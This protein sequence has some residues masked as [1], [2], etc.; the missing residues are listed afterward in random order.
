MYTWPKT[1]VGWKAELPCEGN[2]LS[3]LMHM[4][5][6]ASYQCNITGYWE[7]LNTELCPYISHI[8]KA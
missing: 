5:L 3:G 1:V 8:T 4:P 6:K 7:N 2:H